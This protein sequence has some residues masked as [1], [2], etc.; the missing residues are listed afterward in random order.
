MKPPLLLVPTYFNLS[1]LL[2]GQQEVSSLSQPQK[3][4]LLPKIV[5]PRTKRPIQ[6]GG[7]TYLDLLKE[8]PWV[9]HNGTLHR[10]DLD[11]LKSYNKEEEEG[12]GDAGSQSNGDWTPTATK[13]EWFVL[14]PR[15]VSSTTINTNDQI[16]FAHKPSNMHCVPPRDPLVSQPSLTTQIQS[17]HG[18]TAKPCHRLDYDTSGIVVFGLTKQAH[19]NISKQFEQRLTKKV[20]RALIAG[21]PLED[22]GVI[23]IPIGKRKT[24]QGYNRWAMPADFPKDDPLLLKPRPA[25]THWKILQRYNDDNYSL[26]ELYPQTGRGHQLRLHMKAMGHAILGDTLHAPS[27]KIAKCA[28]R[29]CLQAHRLEV[30]WDGQP[31]VAESIMP[32]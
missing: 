20:Y 6:L 17:I 10:L 8:G 12:D 13:D 24:L 16:L 32:F 5:N 27:S 2:L 26:I 4:L 18:P 11:L 3:S 23:D 19:A 21:H 25:V 15:S 28:P 14:S 9:Q 30:Q 22:S 29:L 31:I 7:A 1:F